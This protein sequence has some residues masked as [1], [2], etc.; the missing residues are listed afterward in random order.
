MTSYLTSSIMAEKIENGRLIAIFHILRQYFDLVGTITLSSIIA[1]GYCRVCS[2]LCYVVF[3][4]A[5]RRRTF[6][7]WLVGMD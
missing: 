6:G 7:H 5:A 2:C 4:L 3:S 1:A